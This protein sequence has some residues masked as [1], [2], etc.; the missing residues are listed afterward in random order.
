MD[1]DHALFDYDLDL[2]GKVCPYPV[3][4]IVQ[5]TDRLEKGQSARFLV[6]DPLAIKSAPE[7]LEEY[8]DI[9]MT[10]EKKG[11]YWEIIVRRSA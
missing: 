5:Q 11:S 10:I 1:S 4:S 8:G 2:T 7:E 3:V 6:D 9:A